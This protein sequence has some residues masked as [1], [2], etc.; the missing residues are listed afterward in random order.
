MLVRHE[1]TQGG[2]ILLLVEIEQH[3]A[4]ERVSHLTRFIGVAADALPASGI[5]Q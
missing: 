1:M 5:P 3:F 4:I 2:K